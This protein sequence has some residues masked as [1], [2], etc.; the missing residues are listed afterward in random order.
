MITTTNWN[1]KKSTR[2]VLAG[3]P[4]YTAEQMQ[5][6]SSL[7]YVMIGSM[8]TIT[9]TAV[10]DCYDKLAER[11]DIFRQA[12]KHHMKEAY[13]RS[14]TLMKVF[15]KYTGEIELFRLWLDVTDSVEE[16]VKSDMVKLFYTTDNILL[17]AGV[18]D[19]V[20]KTHAIVALNMT[21][22]LHDLSQSFC[23]RLLC[24]RPVSEYTVP[25]YGMYTS[26]R[27]VCDLLKIDKE[28]D[29]YKRD[30][31]ISRAMEVLALKVCNLDR[32]NAMSNEALKLNGIDFNREDGQDNAYTEWNDVQVGFL[33]NNY[34]KTT[35]EELAGML[36][37]TVGSIRA[38]ARALKL[39][40]NDDGKDTGHSKGTTATA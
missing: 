8:A 3:V 37:R 26:M 6:A 39:K 18:K 34:D 1:P 35:D 32:L 19:H 36:G 16:D 2:P 27:E 23:R 33:K 5:H 40:R 13:S 21:M 22:M 15:K 38:K 30:G 11:K 9:Q 24:I 12:L 14:E 25:M 20:I 28:A 4:H 7:Y 31:M 10:K 29:Y 17:G